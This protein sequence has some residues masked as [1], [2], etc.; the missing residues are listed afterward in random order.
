MRTMYVIPF[1]V[2]LF[3]FPKAWAGNSTSSFNILD[4]RINFYGGVQ[5][6]EAKGEF[7]STK[8]GLPTVQ[9]DLDD[10]NLDENEVTPIFGLSYRISKRWH[11]RLD[12][13][14][15][16]E[17]EATTADFEF[18]FEDLVIPIGARVDTSI[19]VDIYVANLSYHIVHSKN[20]RFGI[21]VGAHVA[22]LDLDISGKLKV[23]E[24]EV[25]LGEGHEE[26]LAPLPNLYANGAYAFTDNFLL[27]YGGGWISLN[28]DDYEGELV[29][30][31]VFLEY[32][33]F[34]HAGFGIGYRYVEADIDYDSGKK[35][36]KYDIQLPGPMAYVI[37]GF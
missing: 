12:Y 33:P 16:H 4:N 27:R 28:Y 19:D 6:Y 14:G 20:A 30:A 17:D 26:L 18:N 34:R 11:L 13:Y 7:S 36:E 35:V 10:L 32:W 24:T 15:Y 25:P 29:F 2:V 23:N 3:A 31:N 8:E 9:I 21:G 37:F 1:L 22:D 5:R